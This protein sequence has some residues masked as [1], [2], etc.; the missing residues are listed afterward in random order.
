MIILGLHFGH[1]ASITILQDG[2]VLICV[3]LERHRRIKHAIGINY[4]DVIEALAQCEISIN[5]IDYCTI[6]TTQLV[7]YIFTDSK[8][9]Y[10]EVGSNDDDKIS[11]TLI[12]LGIS[13]SDFSKMGIGWLNHILTENPN[14]IYNCLLYTSP[15]PRDL[16]TSRMPSSA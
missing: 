7:E 16:S 14:H 9:L 12:N 15:S 2:K 11:S 10:F 8:K 1:D 4:E 6:T 5:Q 13:S 3:E